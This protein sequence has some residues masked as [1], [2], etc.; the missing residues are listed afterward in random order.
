MTNS[1][2]PK[3][4][5][6]EMISQSVDELM[7]LRTERILNSKIEAL[8]KTSE[9]MLPIDDGFSDRYMSF[10]NALNALEFKDLIRVVSRTSSVASIVLVGIKCL[11]CCGYCISTLPFPSIRN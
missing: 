2:D 5:Y 3:E 9:L 4:F 8:L 1:I 7:Q 6:A 11:H 10:I